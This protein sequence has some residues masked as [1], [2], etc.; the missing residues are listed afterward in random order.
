MAT[1]STVLMK[2]EEWRILS[3]PDPEAGLGALRTEAGALPLLAVSVRAEVTGL[4]Y[5]LRL[6]Q[7]FVNSHGRPLEATYIFPL[8]DRA[9]VSRFRLR[10]AGRLVEGEL[11][12][13]GAARR[14]Y[15]QA[16][17]QGHRAA[18]AEEE[19]PGTFT[20]RVGNI[21]PGE[22]AEVEL[23][24]DGPL[25]FV[26]SEAT[27]RFPL[28]VAP[29]YIPGAPLDGASVGGGTALD[30]DA[31]PDASRISPPVLLP[32]FPSPVRLDLEVR[33][34]PAG[35]PFYGVRSSLHTTTVSEDSAG[36]LTLR[37]QPGERLDRD[38]VL[39]FRIGEDA[40][41]SSLALHPDR[42]GGAEGTFA[43]TL[44]PPKVAG[45][46]PRD[47]VFVLDR[48]GSMGGWKMVA[49]RR[50]MARMVDTL[51]DSDR[52][53]VYA[54]DDR[55]EA[56][57]GVAEQQLVPGSDRRR[58]R[59]V[60]FLAGVEARGGTEM[61]QPLQRAVDLL[62]AGAGGRDRVLVL[63]TDG[64]VGNEA[65][66]LRALGDRLRQVRV[67]SLGIDRAVNEGFLRQLATLGGGACEIVESEARLD[68][69][70]DRVHRQIGTPV[71]TGL[72]LRP[73]GF[74][75]SEGSLSPA[76]LPDLLAEQ[77][78]LIFGRYRDH[79][80]EGLGSLA[81][82]G[83]G[84]DGAARALTVEGLEREDGALARLWARGRLRDLEDRLAVDGA[85]AA[86]KEEIVRTS[87]RFG[88][89]CKLTAF[90]AVDREERV[91]PGGVQHKVTQAVESPDGWG[92]QE[93]E[94]EEEGA[95]A[96]SYNQTRAGSLRSSMPAMAR[97]APM[98]AQAPR[99]KAAAS[100][101][102]PPSP[103][104]PA[105]F[106]EAPAAMAPTAESLA[107]LAPAPMATGAAPVVAPAGGASGK[108]LKDA[109]LQ[110]L[111]M[112]AADEGPGLRGRHAPGARRVSAGRRLLVLLLLL[113]L[114]AI[115]TFLLRR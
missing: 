59:A 70:M 93:E 95:G 80:G 72:R 32:G 15:N 55:I 108:A 40:V 44:V 23:T 67:F 25:F 46:R 50:A 3:E 57:P 114:A 115:L 56:L 62:C 6:R 9:A 20:M 88:V 58:F 1:M 17:A 35:L 39:R 73:A 74:A 10:V 43:L 18:I 104:R 12:E 96:P 101:S 13:R 75:I 38:F 78:A 33:I 28:V 16:I 34:D 79:R 37:L 63:V 94:L 49:A 48:S 68:E 45:R 60:E 112:V 4:L 89:L 86:V 87:L 29:R 8:P 27:F 110:S 24:L 83:V 107:A 92:A 85:D 100:G 52:F 97:S 98:P 51:T 42:E 109:S 54:F 105:R 76:R 21:P 81:V 22:R 14:E 64:Q 91:N 19:R 65:Q 61:A 36:R 5:H 84:P 31:V 11:K 69:V 111:P 30:T 26:E 41:S 102:M 82:E 77:P 47:V 106:E 113:A 53:Q 90:V 66:I 103:G 2:D 99:P 71:L 7:T